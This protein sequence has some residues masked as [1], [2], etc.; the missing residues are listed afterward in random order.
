MSFSYLI[1]SDTIGQSR[2][3]IGQTTDALLFEALGGG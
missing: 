3:G 1:S 2:S